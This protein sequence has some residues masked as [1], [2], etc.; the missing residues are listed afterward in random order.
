MGIVE[1][2]ILLLVA[3]TITAAGRSSTARERYSAA[4]VKKNGN[5]QNM[6]HRIYCS[7]A[8]VVAVWPVDANERSNFLSRRNLPSS[9]RLPVSIA[10][11]I[12]VLVPIHRNVDADID[13]EASKTSS[14]TLH[15]QVKGMMCQK[16]CGTTVA[17]AL[18]NC[19][20]DVVDAGASFAESRAWITVTSFW[21]D[22]LVEEAIDAIE[23]VGFEAERIQSLPEYLAQLREGDQEHEATDESDFEA[24]QS[25]EEEE[26]E[27][28]LES[29]LPAS[30]VIVTLQVRGMSCAV[31]TGR[32]ERALLQ[33]PG[34]STATVTLATHRAKVILQE[35]NNA[36]ESA[37]RCQQAVI[38]AGYDCDLLEIYGSNSQ[39][40]AAGL[41][42]VENAQKMQANRIQEFNSWRNLL[43]LSALF[44]IPLMVA[45]FGHMRLSETSESIPSA[46][47]WFMFLLSTP[48]QIFVG[49]RYYKAAYKG[50]LAGVLG[51]DFL[52]CMG[53]TASYAY[54][55][56]LLA[57]QISTHEPTA[58]D[59]IFPTSAMLLTF[60]TLGK[61]LETYAKGKTANALQKLMELQP[62]VAWRIIGIDDTV[63]NDKNRLA[64]LETNQVALADLRVGDCLRVMPG[65]RIPTDG[66]LI[67]V[68][69]ANPSANVVAYVDESMLTGEPHPVPRAIG[70]KLVG[71]T[72]NQLSVLTMQVTAVGNKTVLAKIV[73]LMEDAQNQKAPIQAMADQIAGKFAPAVICLSLLTFCGWMIC[74]PCELQERIFTAFMSAISV[75]VVACPCALGL[76]TPTAVMVGT[77]VGATQGLLIKGGAVLECMHSVDTVIFD[78]TGTLTTGK[79]VVTARETF[80]GPADPI[81]QNA[82]QHAK[83]DFALWLAG[84]AE[85]QS[86]HPLG[87]AVVNAAKMKWGGDLACAKDG[88]IITEFMISPGLGVECWVATK[89]WGPYV[90]RVGSKVWSADGMG[91]AGDEEI[92]KMRETGQVGVYISIR[93]QSE[94]VRRVVGVIGISDPLK[95]EARAVIKTLKRMKVDVW[96]CTGDHKV[97]ALVVSKQLGINPKNVIAGVKPEEKAD[98][99]T[100]LQ[101][102]R[103]DSGGTDRSGKIAFVGDG[104]NDAVALARAD[105][106]IAI[107]AGT[108]VAVEAADI[109]LVKSTLSDVVVAIHLSK[110]V[111][112]RIRMNFVWALGYNILSLPFAAGLLYPITDYRLPPEFAGL[113]MAFSSVSVVTSSLLLRRYRRPL[114]SEEGPLEKRSICD[115][116][117]AFFAS[118]YRSTSGLKYQDLTTLDDDE[119]EIVQLM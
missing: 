77:G 65:S 31:C 52:I 82:P 92:R 114:I 106:G 64:S 46:E 109:V 42:L 11:T 87:R 67:H 81:L 2:K 1:F 111:F 115:N 83:D 28:D 26:E 14:T 73:R 15:F 61:F 102:N 55:L 60:V 33:L 5:L 47:T 16:S 54:S 8:T 94:N 100:R 44:T 41:T 68:S 53:T 66:V 101:K 57:I 39:G 86:E 110:T 74:N 9:I 30:S 88:V 40:C 107:G 103:A 78:K 76:A 34:V 89:D 12:F 25:Q 96:L 79:A 22:D 118:C 117:S 108:E 48:V 113:M 23:C 93:R 72:V 4:A 80:I 43:I 37:H 13:M 32:V 75:I 116:L 36:S 18:R 70:D 24:L 27:D 90:V 56:L 99:V 38:Q 35:C 45:H 6:K 7:L 119:L 21:S 29:A 17:N 63:V 71:G 91:I 105:V 3:Y 69:S 59:P 95:S 84:C 104:I 19:R 51:M 98:L 62:V 85:L 49:Y 10:R 50:M 97:S 112:Q 20:A 58:L